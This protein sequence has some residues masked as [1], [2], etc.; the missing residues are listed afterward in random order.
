MGGIDD[1]AF[2]AISKILGPFD[3]DL[4]ADETNSKAPR[5]I[6]E[7]RNSL[8]TDWAAELRNGQG[9]LNPPSSTVGWYG[10][11]P[12]A[13]KHVLEAQR[14]ARVVAVWPALINADWFRLLVTSVAVIVISGPTT[15][16]GREQP[17]VLT[18]SNSRRYP[19]NQRWRFWLPDKNTII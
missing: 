1:A 9:W 2:A 12:W 13:E 5:W 6:N 19:A 3:M 15:Y 8:I 14:G 7:A 11:A 16:E 10:L 18:A 4:A 17:L